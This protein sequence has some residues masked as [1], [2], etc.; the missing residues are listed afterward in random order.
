MSICGTVVLDICQRF[1]E[2]WNEIKKRKVMSSSDD[3]ISL[4]TYLFANK[5]KKEEYVEHST[6]FQ[7]SYT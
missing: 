6:G 3:T 7:C 1:I 5:Y 4:Y 2:R